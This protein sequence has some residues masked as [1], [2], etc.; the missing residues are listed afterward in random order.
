MRFWN[1]HAR[2]NA[3]TYGADILAA[4]SDNGGILV[5]AENMGLLTLTQVLETPTG[6]T[7]VMRTNDFGMFRASWASKVSQ[8]MRG[9]H[10]ELNDFAAIGRY[11]LLHPEP[12]FVHGEAQA[13]TAFDNDEGSVAADPASDPITYL[14]VAA[15]VLIST[16][17]VTLRRFPSDDPRHFG[18]LRPYIARRWGLDSTTPLPELPIPENFRPLFQDW[19][20]GKVDFAGPA[21]ED[22]E[23]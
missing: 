18:T 12:P 13:W 21:S 6:L 5:A 20:D 7:S 22:Q 2:Q 14:G 16:E 17:S 23:T 3:L 8:L 11:L 19:A 9:D 15:C 1:D 4:A 10:D